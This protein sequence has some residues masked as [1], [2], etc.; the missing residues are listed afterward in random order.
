MSLSSGKSNLESA[1]VSMFSDVGALKSVETFAKRKAQAINDFALTGIPKTVISFSTPFTGTGIG[2]LDKPAPGMGLPAAKPLLQAEFIQIWTHG[3]AASSPAIFAKKE[4]E[5]IYTYFSQAKVQT[6]DLGPLGSNPEDGGSFFS[7]SSTGIGGLLAPVPGMGYSAA[8]PIL[9]Q[10]LI[11][12]WTQVK[13]ERSIAAFAS[14]MAAAIH[15]FCSQGKVATTGTII[16]GSG[17]SN[18]GTLS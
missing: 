5:A 1:L 12:I 18:S 11:R 7:G 4:A 13:G 10:E 14:E 6:I 3:N 17:T 2:G 8:K 16:A 9:E 15:D